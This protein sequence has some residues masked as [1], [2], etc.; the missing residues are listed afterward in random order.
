MTAHNATM[1]RP[2]FFTCSAIPVKSRYPAL[3]V[4]SC[5]PLSNPLGC[6]AI[7]VGFLKVDVSDVRFGHK[8]K[9]SIRAQNFRFTPESGTHRK[10]SP[11]PLSA[12]SRHN[13]RPHRCTKKK[14]SRL[15]GLAVTRMCRAPGDEVHWT[16]PRSE[17]MSSFLIPTASTHEPSMAGP[18]SVPFA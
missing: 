10:P 6:G 9:Y 1:R 12:R 17:D 7:T 13:K 15:G 14:S 2:R 16:E 3:E 8:R 11:C 5:E 4:G 18:N